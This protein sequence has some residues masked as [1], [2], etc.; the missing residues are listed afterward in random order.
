MWPLAAAWVSTGAVIASQQACTREELA[1]SRCACMRRVDDRAQFYGAPAVEVS[2]AALR[3]CMLQTA[4]AVSG[5]LCCFSRPSVSHDLFWTHTAACTRAC[6]HAVAPCCAAGTAP[7]LRCF[8]EAVSGSVD[9]VGEVHTGNT[10]ANA[11]RR[12][13]LDNVCCH[14]GLQVTGSD[15]VSSR[16]LQRLP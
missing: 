14:S 16:C 5:M 12:V 2:W 15:A 10:R 9:G 13:I 8:G 1:R 3:P 6:A 7:V 11:C 4:C